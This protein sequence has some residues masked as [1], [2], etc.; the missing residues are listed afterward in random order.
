[1]RRLAA[2]VTTI[3]LLSSSSTTFA[4]PLRSQT[5]SDPPHLKALRIEVPPGDDA[6]L[7]MVLPSV[8]GECSSVNVA[9][10]KS[11]L[12]PD[13]GGLSR[14]AFGVL[15]Y[16]TNAALIDVTTMEVKGTDMTSET[17]AGIMQGM[18]TPLEQAGG[19]FVE[20]PSR[21]RVRG[22]EAI[23]AVSEYSAGS[24]KMRTTLVTFFADDRMHQL[25]VTTS[26]DQAAEHAR[27]LE[28]LVST[29]AYEPGDL[30]HF[31]ES[32]SFIQGYRTGK[33]LVTAG[34]P[35]LLL[36]G[37]IAALFT[38]VKRKKAAAAPKE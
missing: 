35:I 7:C 37:V 20:G 22:L 4:E 38:V 29:L 33:L 19:R 9:A 5:V 21:T 15:R 10:L 25:G 8:S 1:M 26:A 14:V 13:P 30:G 34:V 12:A 18:H 27:I 3:A 6:E 32:R 17:L 23:S 24:D 11:N 36:G 2:L 28:H 16:K 31:G